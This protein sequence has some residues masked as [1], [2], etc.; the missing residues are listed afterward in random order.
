MIAMKFVSKTRLL[1]YL[2]AHTLYKVRLINIR[3]N[4]GLNI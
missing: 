4:N 1:I 3:M 2:Y